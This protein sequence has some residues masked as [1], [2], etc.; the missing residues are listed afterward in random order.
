M[1]GELSMSEAEDT[2]TLPPG[3][4]DLSTLQASDNTCTHTFYLG[5]PSSDGIPPETTLNSLKSLLE[6]TIRTLSSSTVKEDYNRMI[7]KITFSMGCNE[8]KKAWLEA[9]FTLLQIESNTQVK[10][11]L[12]RNGRIYFERDLISK[13][14]A[15]YESSAAFRATSKSIFDNI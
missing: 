4:P 12:K 5:S 13:L 8:D 3:Y 6:E 15:S 10:D 1:L 11:A 9:L 7:K 2:Q 14:D